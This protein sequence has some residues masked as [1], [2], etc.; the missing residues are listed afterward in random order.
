MSFNPETQYLSLSF[1]STAEERAALQTLSAW[2]ARNKKEEKLARYFKDM[3]D[4]QFFERQRLSLS[5]LKR[6]FLLIKNLQKSPF[7]FLFQQKEAEALIWYQLKLLVALENH[8]KK[9]EKLT[10]S[11]S[12]KNKPINTPAAEN[13]S[14][15]KYLYLFFALLMLI[16]CIPTILGSF[17]EVKAILSK[18]FTLSTQILQAASTFICLVEGMIFYAMIGPLLQRALGLAVKHKQHT[19]PQLYK[20]QLKSVNEINNRLTLETPFRNQM[21]VE[22][23]HWYVEMASSFNDH[24]CELRLAPFKEQPFKKFFRIGLAA[25]NIIF[26]LIACYYGTLS[27]LS[28]FAPFLVG[29]P[30]GIGIVVSMVIGQQVGRFIL[31][32]DNMF[33][34]LNPMARKHNK[35]KESVESF[36]KKNDTLQDILTHKKLMI[37]LPQQI[38]KQKETIKTI[39][40]KSLIKTLNP[41]LNESKQVGFK[42]L[43]RFFQPSETPAPYKST[44]D[45][46]SYPSQVHARNQS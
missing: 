26:N 20:E 23:Y 4:K 5:E 32:A 2:W 39:A 46:S 19:I 29:T 17:L 3:H 6:R 14:K 31:R 25:I 7:P 21:P 13:A 42:G 1:E 22:K 38:S 10:S 35:I 18:I 41:P 36:Q 43:H 8:L 27:L 33:Y 11:L 12:I 24:I 28:A 45:L 30:L 44:D 37:E 15:K 40:C 9:E 34:Y 16:E